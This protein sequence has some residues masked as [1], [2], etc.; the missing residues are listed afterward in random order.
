METHFPTK[1][2]G[3]LDGSRSLERPQSGGVWAQLV[4]GQGV[5]SDSQEYF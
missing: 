5:F 1:Y 2:Q 3:P 4:R